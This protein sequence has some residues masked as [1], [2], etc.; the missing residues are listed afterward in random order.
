[1]MIS[2]EYLINWIDGHKS[3]FKGKVLDV[4]CGNFRYLEKY[5]D[6]CTLLIADKCTTKKPDIVLDIE[7]ELPIQYLYGF[8]LVLCNQ[9]L[10]HTFNPVF[11]FNNIF[12][13]IVKE[14]EIFYSQPLLCISVMVRETIIDILKVD[15]I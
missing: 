14:G 12:N 9:V 8:N 6:I 10:E 3:M 1:M 15:L 5:R 2:R 7:K 13:L 11:A 4:G